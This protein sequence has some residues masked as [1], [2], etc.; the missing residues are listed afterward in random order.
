MEERSDRIH[1]GIAVGDHHALRTRGRAA[2]V[3]DCEQVRLVDFRA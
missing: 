3:I 1:P 2:G